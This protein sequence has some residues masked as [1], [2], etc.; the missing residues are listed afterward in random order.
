MPKWKNPDEYLAALDD[1]TKRA[2]LERLRGQIRR[3]AP[4]AEECLS[5]GVPAFCYEGR[6]LVAYAA[7]AQHC[8]FYPLSPSVIET[9]ASELEG[10][11]LSKGTIRFQPTAPLKATLVHKI[12]KARLTEL[13]G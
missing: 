3:A 4:K 10:Y 2:A 12:V 1:D 8:G 7:F 13:K 5:Y 6:A 9:F 11:P